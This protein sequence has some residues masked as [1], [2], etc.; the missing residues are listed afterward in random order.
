M[1]TEIQLYLVSRTLIQMMFLHTEEY[2][3]LLKGEQKENISVFTHIHTYIL[4]FELRVSHL[5]SDVLLLEP[6]PQHSCF[7]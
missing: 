2:A 6:H 4:R 1:G 3:K 5:N 7:S